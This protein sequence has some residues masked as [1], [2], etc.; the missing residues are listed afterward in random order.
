MSEKFHK[1]S[2]KVLYIIASLVLSIL[3]LGSSMFGGNPKPGEVYADISP[4]PSPTPPSPEPCPAP[5]CC[6]T[7]VGDNDCVAV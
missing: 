6:A 5:G 2:K 3:S 7:C 4:S 1:K